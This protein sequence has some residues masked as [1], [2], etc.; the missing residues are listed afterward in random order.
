MNAQEFCLKPF[1]A[2][3]TPDGHHTAPDIE[4]TGTVAVSSDSVNVTYLISGAHDRVKSAGVGSQPSRKNDLWRTTCFEL[5]VKAP[6][7]NPYWE[8]NLSP[9]GDWNI[10]RFTAY[11]SPLQQETHITDIAIAT[12]RARGHLTRLQAV[13]PLPPPLIGKPLAI[14]ISSV[15]EDTAGNL[16][17]FALQHNGDKPNFHDPSGFVLRFE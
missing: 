15:I 10:Y 13:L 9:N 8:Y 7:G 1:R 6:V 5:F 4:I 16:F 14:G 2:S 11:R 12:A 17:Y 3:A